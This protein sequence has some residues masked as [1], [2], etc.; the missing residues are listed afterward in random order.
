MKFLCLSA[1]L[2]SALLMAGNTQAQSRQT[3]SLQQC[4]EQ[5]I[6]SNLQVKQSQI[7][8]QNNLLTANRNRGSLLPNING[9]ATHSY[10]FGRSLDP[11][12]YQFVDQRIQSNN[13]SVNGNVVLFSGLQIQNS[14]KQSLLDYEA[15]LLDIETT[16]NNIMLQVVMAYL[17]ILFAEEL[18]QTN[19]LLR[20]NTNA[21]LTRTQKLFAAGSVAESNVIEL[22]AQS[23]QDE[24]N[25]I[26]AQNQ[27]D[28]AVLNLIQLMNLKEQTDLEIVRPALP[29]PSALPLPASPDLV[30][31]T[32]LGNQPQIKSAGVRE[33][34]AIVGIKAAR[35][36]Y[37]PTLSLFGNVSTIYS[38]A[39]DQISLGPDGTPVLSEYSFRE[40]VKDY[41]G[42]SVGLSLNIPILNGFQVRNNVNRAQLNHQNAQLQSEMAKQDLYQTIQQS[43][44]DARAAEKRF[45]AATNQLT[46]FE[47]AFTNAQKRFDA[48]ILNTTDFN[49]SKNNFAR[50]QSD[51]IQ[52]KFDYIFRLKVL[53]F[54]Q[55]KP[56]TL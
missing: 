8:A 17:N 10:N 5:A 52:A 56:I 41:L 55:G 14:I 27:R 53:D 24:L 3:W 29:D 40:Q 6:N 37:Y 21:Q 7:N 23:S 26:T 32:A 16:R 45:I 31:Q 48:G 19:T 15:G 49:V 39:R 51:L 50:A 4:I 34:S 9:N 36:G 22:Q 18:V 12:T 25:I 28:L 46:S 13:F 38:S 1:A 30:Y 43:Y 35:G 20:D 11:T 54:Y 42:R 47:L 44:T 33:Q 2:L